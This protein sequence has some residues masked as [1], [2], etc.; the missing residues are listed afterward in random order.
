MAHRCAVTWL[1]VTVTVDV[2][3]SFRDGK[4][5]ERDGL[6]RGTLC[7]CRRWCRHRCGTGCLAGR[8][9]HCQL[10]ADDHHHLHDPEQEDEQHR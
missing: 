2:D 1:T 5:T 9:L 3:E 6:S 10:V 7:G 4:R 8:Q